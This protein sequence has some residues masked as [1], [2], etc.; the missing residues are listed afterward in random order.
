M[1]RLYCCYSENQKN[2]LT[3]NG[4]RYEI[5]A[6]NPNNHKMMWVYMRSEELSKKLTEWTNGSK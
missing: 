2:F 6:L 3:Q 4:I 5:V 1:N